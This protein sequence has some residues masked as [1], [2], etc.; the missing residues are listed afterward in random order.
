MFISEISEIRESRNMPSHI[1]REFILHFGEMGSRWGI[2]RTVGQIYALLFLSERPLC[3]DDICAALGFSRSNVSMGL[4]ELQGWGLVRRRDLEGDRRDHFAT[5]D[6][7]WQIV[8]TLIAE[9]KKR[10]IDPTLT[11]LRELEMQAPEGAETYALGRI[12]QLREMIETLTGFYEEMNRME[13]ERLVAL[14]K[15]GST[16]RKFAA[17]TGR[18]VSLGKGSK[19]KEE[20]S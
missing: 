13:T 10:E 14:L 1:Q 12:G 6:D 8:R 2:N 18:V 5:L 16:L 11:K 15:M 9:R 20:T 3:A 19:S 17:T 4:K 7:Q